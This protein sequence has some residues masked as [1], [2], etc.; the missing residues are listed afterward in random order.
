MEKDGVGGMY[1]K[2]YPWYFIF[3]L[4]EYYLFNKINTIKNKVSD[5]KE[6]IGSS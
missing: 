1:L 2:I 3:E 4:Y 5:K 6:I